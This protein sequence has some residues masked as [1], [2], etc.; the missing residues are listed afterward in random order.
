MRVGGGEGWMGVG[1]G[2]W[3]R[4]ECWIGKR[5]ARN[6]WRGQVGRGEATR[7]GP[8]FSEVTL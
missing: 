7:L 8:R 6:P 5:A 1:W 4:R 2:K 3:V